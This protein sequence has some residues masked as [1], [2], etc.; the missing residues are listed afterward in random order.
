MAGRDERML[1]P[2]WLHQVAEYL[3]GLVL[4]AIG[5]QSPEPAVPS[6]LGGVIV[7]NAAFVDGPVGAFRAFDRRTHRILDL[8][9]IG[10]LVA[11]AAIPGLPVDNTNRVT[12][13]AV[14]VVLLVVWWNSSFAAKAPK[15]TGP[16]V[17]RSEAIGRGAGGWPATPAKFVRDRRGRE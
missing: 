1:R 8:V 11:A 9:V 16:P 3:I 4:I 7:I 12:M 6:I 15:G 2:F 13:I 10:A 5:L 14:A 17:D